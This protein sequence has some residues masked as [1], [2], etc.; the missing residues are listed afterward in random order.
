MRGLPKGGGAVA[1]QTQAFISLVTSCFKDSERP[2][3]RESGSLQLFSNMYDK[4]SSAWSTSLDSATALVH[5]VK[6]CKAPAL[7]G[8]SPCG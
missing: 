8:T 1:W 2:C 4:E 3:G 5:A 6:S 7:K